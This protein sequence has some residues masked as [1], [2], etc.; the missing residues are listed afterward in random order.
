[1]A[2]TCLVF[3]FYFLIRQLKIQHFPILIFEALLLHFEMKVLLAPM[4]SDFDALN[5]VFKISKF[6]QKSKFWT[7]IKN[8]AKIEIFVK[9]ENSGQKSEFWAKIQILGKNRNFGQKS[10]FWA[11]IEILG[12]NRNFGQKSKF[13]ANGKILDTNS[14]FVQKSVFSRKNPNFSQKGKFWTKIQNIEILTTKQNSMETVEFVFTWNFADSVTSKDQLGCGW[15]I[16]GLCLIYFFDRRLFRDKFGTRFRNIFISVIK[17]R[18][19]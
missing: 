6:V 12:K 16:F 17:S 13:W 14:N 7:K 19:L 1:L 4:C 10:K 15:S 2:V 11:E 3:Y 5:R 8:L 9:R 18:I